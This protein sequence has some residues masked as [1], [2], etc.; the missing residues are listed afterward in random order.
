MSATKANFKTRSAMAAR[1]LT[2]P[3]VLALH[4][5]RVLCAAVLIIVAPILGAV[6]SVLA[7]GLALA[8]CFFEWFSAVPDFPFWPMLGA[9]LACAVARLALDRTT[10]A[11]LSS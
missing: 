6:L 5:A 11:L 10:A 3:I 9:A 7:V 1:W 4:I 2:A 8:A